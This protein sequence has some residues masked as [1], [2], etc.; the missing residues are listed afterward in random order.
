MLFRSASYLAYSRAQYEA[1]TI[2]NRHEVENLIEGLGEYKK[3]LV[4]GLLET[5]QLS[6]TDVA[7]FLDCDKYA[8]KEVIGKL[9]RA[10]CLYKDYTFYVKKP[11]FI[12]LLRRIR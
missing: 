9:V 8:A 2:P 12:K 5:K 1:T 11:A 10:K 7:D 4:G 3:S 6:I